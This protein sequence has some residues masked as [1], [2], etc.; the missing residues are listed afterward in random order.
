MKKNIIQTLVF[1]VFIIVSV[2]STVGVSAEE[3]YRVKSS[4]NLKKIV[5]R[6]YADSDL[7]KSQIYVG[8]LERNPSAFKNGN[9]NALMKGRR[10]VLPDESTIQFISKDYVEEILSGGLDK[11]K[12]RRNKVTNTSGTKN[13][14][15]IKKLK[16]KQ[17]QQTK[18]IT[19]LKKEGNDLKKRLETLILEKKDRD[20][21]LAKLEISLNNTI[22]DLKT[23]KDSSP[24]LSNKID[25]LVKY[26][27]ENLLNENEALQE[28]LKKS[29]SE[30]A[31][32]NNS[33][34]AL[35][36]RFNDLQDYQEEKSKADSEPSLIS[37]KNPQITFSNQETINQ[38]NGTF[39][40]LPWFI[41]ALGLL[42][43][44]L[45]S[46]LFLKKKK[47]DDFNI[48][49]EFADV[50]VKQVRSLDEQSID[51]TFEEVP[52][53]STIK[54]DMAR[55]Y[56]DSGD[57]VAAQDILQEVVNNGSL[58]QIK[59]AEEILLGIQ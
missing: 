15:K 53:E 31:E 55:A 23:K 44:S 6:F 45:I 28:Q 27:T 24:D 11:K 21:K 46:W 12:K 52:L 8:I 18:Q 40:K 41:I 43:L 37:S 14:N 39:W 49:D 51:K 1:R 25:K 29:K 34:M 20:I 17:N 36:R 3:T 10:L 9:I 54:L 56:I 33:T 16:K 59:Q 35:Q 50:R 48:S 42:V 19:D 58:D 7:S 22:K 38:D 13:N 5:N 4:D 2:F 30:L 26:K 32:N 57:I 47:D